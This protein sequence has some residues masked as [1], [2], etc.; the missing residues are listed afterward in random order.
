MHDTNTL[1]TRCDKTKRAGGAR[2]FVT[3]AAALAAMLVTTE[4]RAQSQG[5]AQ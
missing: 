1:P 4:A 3:A 5:G 2:A